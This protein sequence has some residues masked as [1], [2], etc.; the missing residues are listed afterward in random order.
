MG[1]IVCRDRGLIWDW[2]AEMREIAELDL[3]ANRY[4][5]DMPCDNL[6]ITYQISVKRRHALARTLFDDIRDDLR[7][8]APRQP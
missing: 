2:M 4:V 5:S 3:V 8:L 7:H 1:G 6:L